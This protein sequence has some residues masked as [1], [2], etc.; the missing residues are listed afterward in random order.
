[1]KNRRHVARVAGLSDDDRELYEERVA[2]LER[3]KND[4]GEK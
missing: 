4:E 3:A 2:R 1:M